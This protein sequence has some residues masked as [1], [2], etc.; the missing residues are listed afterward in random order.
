M[1]IQHLA[2]FLILL[3][4]GYSGWSWAD[5]L[6]PKQKAVV[7]LLTPAEKWAVAEGA[8]KLIITPSLEILKKDHGKLANLFVMAMVGGS[9][10]VNSGE[11][12]WIHFS[13]TLPP[14]RRSVIL[15]DNQTFPIYAGSQ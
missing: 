10:F 12:G 5:I 11:S 7:D 8:E 4:L 3:T 15:G 6:E 13:G 9:F 2:F 14:F 1:K